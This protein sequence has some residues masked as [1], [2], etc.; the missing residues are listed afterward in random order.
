MHP[1][2]AAIACLAPRL[3]VVQHLLKRLSMPVLSG[4]SSRLLHLPLSG[5]LLLCPKGSS[6]SPGAPQLPTM[7]VVRPLL[8]KS[9]VLTLWRC[10][11]TPQPS[12]SSPPTLNLQPSTLK[13]WASTLSPQPSTFNLNPQPS[14]INTQNSTFIPSNRLLNPQPSTWNPAQPVLVCLCSVWRLAS[15]TPDIHC[16]NTAAVVAL[17]RHPVYWMQNWNWLQRR[18]IHS[19][20][21]PGRL[22]LPAVGPFLKL[23]EAG[24]GG[25]RVPPACSHLPSGILPPTWISINIIDI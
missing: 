7:P 20:S 2:D 9:T 24:T 21:G 25:H 8:S 14:N 22:V 5:A 15:S 12:T 23:A 11:L 16:I 3:E 4:P 10:F 13:F 1:T 18:N 19:D 6:G 17:L